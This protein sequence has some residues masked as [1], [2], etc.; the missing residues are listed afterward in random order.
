M[1]K[2]KYTN[3]ELI[4]ANNFSKKMFN[5]PLEDTLEFLVENDKDKNIDN[6]M[7]ALI[8]LGQFIDKDKK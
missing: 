2:K 3:Q 8:E 5:A 1:N 7:T 4:W 6:V